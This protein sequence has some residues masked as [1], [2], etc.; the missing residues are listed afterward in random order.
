VTITNRVSLKSVMAGVTPIADVPDA[1][2]IGAATNVGTSRAFNNGSATVAY[3]AA[4][5]GGTATTFTATSTPGSFTGTGTSPITVTGLQ[6]A[7]SYTFT[8]TPTNSTATGPASAASSSIT[9]TTVPATMSAPTPTNVGTSRAFNNGAA[10]VAFTAPATG[11]SA[12]SSYTVTSSPGG[13]T[14]SGASSP[15]TVTGLASATAYTYTITATNANG[16]STASSASASVTSTTVPAAPTIGTATDGG[17]G[18]TVSVPFTAGATGG[19]AITTYTATS[20]P[21]SITGTRAS[22]PITVSG[23]TAGTAYTFT[24]TATNANGVSAASSASNSVTPSIPGWMS[25]IYTSSFFPNFNSNKISAD[26][27]GNS[28]RGGT[29]NGVGFLVKR[30]SSGSISFQRQYTSSNGGSISTSNLHNDSSGN[31]YWVGQSNITNFPTRP[32]A[33]VTKLD[34]SGA[35]QW[36]KLLSSNS[37][38]SNDY[39]FGVCTDSSGNV[40]ATGG[41]RNTSVTAQ[42]SYMTAKYNSSGVL[43]WYSSLLPG[44]SGDT[45]TTGNSVAVDSS[46]NV[47]SGGVMQ[48]PSQSTSGQAYLIK[49]NS[50][51][52]VQWQKS[53][54][55]NTGSSFT[56]N[57]KTIA[58]DSSANIYTTGELQLSTSPTNY[59][60]YVAKFNTSGTR[61]WDT[62]VY[63]TSNSG[64]GYGLVLDSSG[65][66]YVAGQVQRAS[67]SNY[68]G[69]LIKFNS[70]G[71][72]QW[73]RTF[74]STYSTYIYGLAID[75]T[76]STLFV[77]GQS[78]YTDNSDTYRFEHKVPLDGSKTGTYNINGLASQT[79]AASS[80]TINA[81]SA[82]SETAPTTSSGTT[83]TDEVN[84][85]TGATLSSPTFYADQV[86]M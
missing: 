83:A 37:S 44:I 30:A 74:S 16:T 78:R 38:R 63:S 23:L 13:F 8:V 58:V 17:T 2:T 66:V 7:T 10:S 5:T 65:N 80:L 1:P 60:A 39:F 32:G 73:Q 28:Y 68:D 20:S 67:S 50:S 24:V 6:S 3:T 51:G 27:S 47:Y 61:Q 42:Y 35:I 84:V 25:L 36:Q 18:T 86:T 70:A 14:A 43:Q 53:Y 45:A 31:L 4:P 34:S 21:G 72:V 41:L 15:L 75:E 85:L 40:Y 82:I 69:F 62:R 79:Y 64:T 76:N 81:T 56:S 59:P 9:A 48:L 55:G 71:T 22:S 11:G 33:S 12:I 26:S 19:S 52:T 49:Y 29:V 57:I 77:S 54:W 46:G